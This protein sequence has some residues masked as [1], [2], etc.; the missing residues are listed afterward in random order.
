MSRISFGE[1]VDYLP[2]RI[3]LIDRNRATRKDAGFCLGDQAARCERRNRYFQGPQSV[4]GILDPLAAPMVAAQLSNTDN[5]PHIVA[6]LRSCIG[7]EQIDYPP[8]LKR[9]RFRSANLYEFSRLSK[10]ITAWL[11]V[12]VRRRIFG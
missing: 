3:I 1:T 8:V 2:G 5:M 10:V 7:V 4:D 6:E 12:D 11:L 9:E